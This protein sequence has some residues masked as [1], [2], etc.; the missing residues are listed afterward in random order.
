M[1]G[2]YRHNDSFGILAGFNLSSFINVGYSYD[3]TT[4][5]LNTVSNGTHEIVIGLLLNN[6]YKVT[7]PQHG[8]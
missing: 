3:I 2:S 1:G 7:C 5:S 4:S 8:F 6:R